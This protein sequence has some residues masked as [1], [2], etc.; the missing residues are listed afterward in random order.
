MI[1]A[2]FASVITAISWFG[3]NLLGT[4]LHSYGFTEKGLLSFTLFIA[5][6]LGIVFMAM[7]IPMAAWRS[8]DLANGNRPQATA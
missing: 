7:V 3:V 5:V 2:S 1:A 6:E 4:G 8:N